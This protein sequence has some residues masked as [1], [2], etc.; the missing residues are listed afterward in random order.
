MH[1]FLNDICTVL[2][3]KSILLKLQEKNMDQKCSGFRELKKDL[4]IQMI[5][6]HSATMR[7]DNEQEAC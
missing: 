6:V 2:N 3:A 5:S 4:R 7:R 1:S